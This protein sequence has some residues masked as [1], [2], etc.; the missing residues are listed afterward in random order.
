MICQACNTEN[1]DQAKFC[2]GCGDALQ[3]LCAECGTELPA[4]AKF[5]FSCGAKVGDPA[6]APTTATSPASATAEAPQTAAESEALD[7]LAQYVPKELLSKLESARAGG[8]MAGERRVVT[9]LFCDVQGST[10]AA[11]AL[12]PEDW[13]EIINGAFE[14]LIAPVYKYEGTL[15]RLMGDAILAFFGAP[16]AHEDDPQRAVLAGLE[17]LES[18]RPYAEEI[19]R[20]WGF[21]LAVRVGINTGL[22][23][24]G[25][26]GSDLRVEYSA[27]GDA[28]NIAARMEQ[29]AAPNTLQITAETQRLIAPFFDFSDLGGIEV[30]G[31]EEPIQAYR[32]NH[33]L[34]EM[35]QLRGI[36]GLDSPLVG[37]ADEMETLKR[38][39]SELADG[40]GQIVSLMGEAG[41]GKSR[42]MAELQRAATNQQQ[43]MWLEGRSLSYETETPYAPF[44]DVVISALADAGLDTSDFD[45]INFKSAL[46]KLVPESASTIAPH[47]A[48]L[49]GT[50][51]TGEDLE[52]VRYLDPPRA[53]GKTFD[54]AYT[55]F[56]ELAVKRSLILVFDDLHWVDPTSLELIK[57]LMPIADQCPF[58]LIGVYRP[59]RNERSWEFFESASR[60]FAHRHVEVTL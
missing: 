31:K 32:V 1:P 9:M 44:A 41:L 4:D 18:V 2:M 17:I 50:S 38:A 49:A 29:T 14:H 6:L 21:D 60:D 58:M 20:K 36:E 24:V 33:A 48:T 28:I 7:R 22:V 56:Q 12:D 43:A 52:V 13:A 30:K 25:E 16:I 3:N 15:A 45:Y 39:A 46:T 53:K 11:G 47:L 19:Q 55:F 26:V 35:G 54:A 42:L 10:A 27:L 59:R 23:V 51:P 57:M 5:C 40:R 8:S 34:S 37:R